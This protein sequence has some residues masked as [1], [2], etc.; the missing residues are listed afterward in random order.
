MKL[1]FP[2]TITESVIITII[3]FASLAA[4]ISI[5]KEILLRE[6]DVD[7]LM[8]VSVILAGVSTYISAY[9]LNDKRLINFNFKLKKNNWLTLFLYIL[10]SCSFFVFFILPILKLINTEKVEMPFLNSKF[11]LVGGLLIGP[12][13]EEIIFRGIILR[14]L[15]VKIP[16]KKAILASTIFFAIIHGNPN[17]IFSAF[18]MGL[19][20]GH[21]YYI[22]KSILAVI[23]LH[24]VINITITF[25]TLC[26]F[27]FGD[28]FYFNI[29][30]SYSTIILIV[31]FTVFIASF[32]FLR[33][34]IK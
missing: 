34:R 13:I 26:N 19:I 17:Q 15:L 21:L 12:I 8:L 4:I 33:K 7:F 30:G 24:I 5:L 25:F 23:L 22:T 16:H 2:N 18:F 28:S 32:F 1:K 3:Y 11:Y 27:K 10:F 31:S 20:L 29:Y 14:G 6:V 9:Y